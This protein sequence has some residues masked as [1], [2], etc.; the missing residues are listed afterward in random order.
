[1]IIDG[2][3][4]YDI[5]VIF[6]V[7]ANFNP[8]IKHERS[9]NMAII[10]TRKIKLS[11]SVDDLIEKAK[12]A[13]NGVK[14]FNYDQNRGILTVN[15]DLELVMLKTIEDVLQQQGIQLD[16]G[17]FRKMKRGWHHYTEQNELDN[18]HVNPTC[19]SDP[20]LG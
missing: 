4:K 2:L 1:M 11:H 6:K 5:S 14:E 13:L 8:L 20:K 15:Y 10:K 12:Q 19:C 3:I 18:L 16:N 7:G 17:F 9:K